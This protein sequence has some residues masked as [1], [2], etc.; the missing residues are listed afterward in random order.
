MY[1]YFFVSM[2]IPDKPLDLGIL[3]VIRK[4]AINGK[5]KL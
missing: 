2:T 3:H 4:E 1:S 5:Q